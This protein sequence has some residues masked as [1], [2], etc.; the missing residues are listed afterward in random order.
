M[1]LN[2]YVRSILL[3]EHIM[4][5]RT[6]ADS[7]NIVLGH[8]FDCVLNRKLPLLAVAREAGSMECRRCYCNNVGLKNDTEQLYGVGV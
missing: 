8:V 7:P 3:I 6:K 2:L 1:L 4:E 5:L